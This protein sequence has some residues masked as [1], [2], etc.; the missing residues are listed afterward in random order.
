MKDAEFEVTTNGQ[1]GFP[2]KKPAR[3]KRMV[4]IMATRYSAPAPLA[5]SP[6]R[7]AE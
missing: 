2:G 6:M 4:P 3:E 5:S 7:D 1:K